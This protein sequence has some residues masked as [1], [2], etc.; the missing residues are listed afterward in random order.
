M[1]VA[2]TCLVLLVR[3]QKVGRGRKRQSGG[4]VAHGGGGV[5]EGGKGQ[6][7]AEPREG[8]TGWEGG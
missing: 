4:K 2:N 1:A 7:E 8:N 5:M 3:D 6:E